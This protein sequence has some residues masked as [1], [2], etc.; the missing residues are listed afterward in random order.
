MNLNIRNKILGL[1][2]L[3]LTGVSAMASPLT[4]QVPESEKALNAPWTKGAFET[5]QY[6]NVFAEMGYTQEE[7]DKRVQTVFNGI[8]SPKNKVYVEPD[9]STAYICDIVHNDVR[10]EGMSYGMMIAVQFN[11]KDIFDRLWRWSKTYMQHKEGPSEGYFAWCCRTDG[12]HIDGGSASDGELYFITSLIFASNRWGNETG[13]NYLA[14]ARHILDCALKKDGTGGIMPLIHKEH[15]LIT[16][17]P[18]D[19]GYAFTDPSYHLPAFYEVWAR[20]A[21][22]GRSDYW[23]ECAERSRQYLHKAVHPVTGLTPD[24][25]NYDGSLMHKGWMIGDAF[26]FD[27]W[28]VP[29]NIALDYSWSCAD[30]EW[31]QEYANKIQDFLYNEGIDTFVNQ[32]N[33]DGTMLPDSLQMGK[34]SHA[35]GL[36]ATAAAASLVCTHEKGRE[37]VQRLWDSRPTPGFNYY[38]DGL[39]RLFAFMHLSGKYQVIFPESIIFKKEAVSK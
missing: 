36:V 26:R 8:F 30:R 14:D 6:R 7:I 25:S 29:M 11:R 10:S 37:F 39:L 3:L 17:V 15:K 20:W 9:D 1:S 4:G 27:S 5:R 38:Y 28:R 18:N 23:N 35:P 32:Y 31:Q 33:V 12:S 19:F 16:F 24:Y 34:P 21:D 22:D 2:L 13:I